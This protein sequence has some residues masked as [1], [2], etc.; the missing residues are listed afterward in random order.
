MSNIPG[1]TQTLPL[2]IYNLTQSPD[3]DAAI[4]RLCALS[5]ALSLAA[6][7]LSEWMTRRVQVRQS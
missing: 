7:V 1:E 2:A 6:L 5:V 4:L 3:S